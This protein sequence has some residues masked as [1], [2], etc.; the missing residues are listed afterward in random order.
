MV[1]N[2]SIAES[3]IETQVGLAVITSDTPVDL[4]DNCFATTRRVTSVSVMIPARP[5]WALT[6]RAASP[7]LVASVCVTASTLCDA[8]I[9]MGFFGRSFETGLS[10]F[11]RDIFADLT[12]AL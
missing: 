1:T 4:A 11:L 5:P 3:V 8:S 12:E 6:I 9:N 7:L 2:A 10:S